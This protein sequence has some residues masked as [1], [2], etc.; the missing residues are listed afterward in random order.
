MAPPLIP[1]TKVS[2][3]TNIQSTI[4]T[5]Y[6]QQVLLENYEYFRMLYNSNKNVYDN[7]NNSSLLIDFFKIHLDKEETF[8]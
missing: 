8:K 5:A 3:L 7:K 6:S 1:Y 2:Q 4:I